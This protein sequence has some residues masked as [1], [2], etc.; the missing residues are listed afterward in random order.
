MNKKYALITGASSGIGEEIA[1]NLA[2]KGFN[3][4]VTARRLE[5]LNNLSKDICSQYD[6]DVRVIS[7]DLSEESA[8]N[9]IYEFCNK[10]G[11]H[12]DMIV[13]N[14]GYGI[15]T[16]FHETSMIEEEK[17]LRVLGTSVIGLTKA[18]IP[19][20]IKNK[21]GKI[22]IIS[23]V[24]SFA[25]PSVI[26]SLYGP[27]KT[28]MNRFGD[29]L[30]ALYKR[31]GISSTVVCPGYTVTEFHSASGVQ[32][33]M[34]KVPEFLKLNVKKVAEEAIQA[35]LKGKTLCIPSKRYKVLV[36]LLK[37]I[38]W[39]VFQLIDITGGRYEKN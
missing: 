4:V 26:Q 5:R 36:F 34:D 14:A 6:V 2:S 17:F 19:E 33:Q 10:N 9:E 7:A 32:E 12:I 15:P 30:N 11:L 20:M 21:S 37:V 22:M 28:F 3:L 23:S 27:V 35:T 31:D 24:A 13:N 18:F 1:R 8:V 25:P 38:P 29:T 16:Q 39:K